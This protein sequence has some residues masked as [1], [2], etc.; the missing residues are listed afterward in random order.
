MTA[1]D[2]ERQRS[3]LAAVTHGACTRICRMTAL[4]CRQRTAVRPRRSVRR[5]RRTRIDNNA[6]SDVCVSGSRTTTV[7]TSSAPSSSEAVAAHCPLERQTS[8][9]STTR[10]LVEDIL[11]PDFGV[12][13][14]TC[15]W[16]DCVSWDAGVCSL[17]AG[18]QRC[19]SPLSTLTTCNIKC[20]APTPTSTAST[21]A[22]ASPHD[23]VTQLKTTT[24]SGTK[25]L[26]LDSLPAWIFC[27]RYSD[28]P[29]LGT[30]RPTPVFIYIA[31]VKSLRLIT[32][33]HCV[34]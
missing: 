34:R 20:P 29:P 12:R 22:S 25:L 27:T 18:V 4:I 19:S 31:T 9:R 24:H 11:R 7:C 16:N 28:R 23:D 13:R 8:R 21:S 2:S 30:G 17:S 14:P 15:R 6:T 10:F 5:R 1:T 3:G 26:D 33:V 32:G